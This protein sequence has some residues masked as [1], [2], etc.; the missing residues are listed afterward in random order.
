MDVRV[1]TIKK[2]EHQRIDAFELW[3]WR[4]S[5][6]DPL[7]CKEIKPVNPKG[8]HSWIY[9]GRTEDE[10]D[11][12]IL[13]PPDVKRWLIGKDPDAGKDWGHEEKGATEDEVVGWHHQL[14]EDEFEQIPGDGDG[15]GS[16][17]CCS[18]WGH[19]EADMTERLKN[20][21]THLAQWQ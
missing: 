12:P 11:T 18:P 3:C 9:T 15:Q 10:A 8:N 7:D 5:L 19:K 2:A 21:K 20:N 17:G 14:N 1:W 13:W 4:R 16:L 6:R